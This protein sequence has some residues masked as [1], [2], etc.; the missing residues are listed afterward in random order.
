MIKNKKPF[1]MIEI[2]NKEKKIQE[3]TLITTEKS[4]INI[5]FTS[6]KF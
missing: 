2:D 5:K 4:T 3:V 6:L 1:T